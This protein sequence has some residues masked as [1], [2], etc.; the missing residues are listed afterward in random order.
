MQK[1]QNKRKQGI[2]PII[3]TLLLILIAIAAGVVV[4]AYVIGFIGNST[5]N[6]GGA[7]STVSIDNSCISASG[8]SGK[9]GTGT[10]YVAL[11]VRNVG[12]TTIAGSLTSNVYLTDVTSGTTF[13]Y[14]CT[15][16]ATAPGSTFS[17]ADT[18]TT[19][20]FSSGDTV[21]LKIVMPDGGEST[22][23]VKAIA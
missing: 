3:A 2:S 5:S 13:S 16:S 23:S 17:C 18:T 12:T 7:Q 8:A 10:N 11:T 19:T 4:Y 20:G 15:T 22:S 14:T 6:P 1:I 9:C 21:S